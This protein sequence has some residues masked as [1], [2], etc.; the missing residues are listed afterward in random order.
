MQQDDVIV[1]FDGKPVLTAG[2]FQ[3]QVSLFQPGTKVSVVVLRNGVKQSLTVELGTRVKAR[4]SKPTPQPTLEVAGMAVQNLSQD[5]AKQLNYQGAT[6]VVVVAVAQDSMAGLSGLGPGMLIQT[7]NR[8]P[9][10]NLQE[11]ETALKAAAQ[12]PPI[13]FLVNNQGVYRYIV[14]ATPQ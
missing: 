11:F 13:L 4:A 14:L 12:K 2:A 8:Q 3:T 10:K 7:V 9:I 6:G 1:Q 5:L